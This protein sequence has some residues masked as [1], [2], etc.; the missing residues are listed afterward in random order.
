MLPQL[1]SLTARSYICEWVVKSVAVRS[2]SEFEK[3]WEGS[4][5][6]GGARGGARDGARVAG[7]GLVA[8]VRGG[9]WVG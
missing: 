1:L 3:A 8:G 9:L 5:A 6:G 4:G 2:Q 7:K